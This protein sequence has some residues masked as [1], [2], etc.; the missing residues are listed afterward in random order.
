M[1]QY[2]PLPCLMKAF[3][4]Q[5]GGTGSYDS[6]GSGLTTQQIKSIEKHGFTLSLRAR[7]VQGPIN[8][9][10]VNLRHL[11]ARMDRFRSSETHW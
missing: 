3:Y 4:N 5:L 11:K 6:G 7:V 8:S 1:A 2:R 10:R 9:A